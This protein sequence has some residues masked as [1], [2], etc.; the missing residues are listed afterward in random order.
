MAFVNVT[1]STE[2]IEIKVK[3]ENELQL[4]DSEDPTPT[5]L[6]QEIKIEP[7]D[8][9]ENIPKIT[10]SRDTIEIKV[11]QEDEYFEY[12]PIKEESGLRIIDSR[13]LVKEEFDIN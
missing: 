5:D 1:D 8:D 11:E 13:S 6:V 10:D 12:L 4:T 2:T 3:V 9:L 7:D